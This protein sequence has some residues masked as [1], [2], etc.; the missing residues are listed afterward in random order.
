MRLL[1]LLTVVLL[2]GGCGMFNRSARAPLPPPA[3]AALPGG[4]QPVYG[5]WVAGPNA[6]LRAS[7]TSAAAVIGKLPPGL[8]VK[9]VGRTPG[10]DWVAV[11]ATES[12]GAPGAMAY[13]KLDVLR[14]REERAK[15]VGNITVPKPTDQSGPV[16][17]AAPRS[18]VEAAPIQ[19]PA[20]RA[21]P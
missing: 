6:R 17:K 10:T 21:Q 4:L 1:L 15:G 5:E 7:P 2:L 9:V 11:F 8:P 20:P 3:K 16:V 14:L 12:A 18:K 13:V 19:P